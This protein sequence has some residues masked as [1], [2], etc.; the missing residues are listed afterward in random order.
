MGGRLNQMRA[1][2][3]AVEHGSF[4]AAAD[5]LGL[6]P[7]MAGRHI[8]DLERELRVRLFDRTTRQTRLTEAGAAYYERAKDALRAVAMADESVQAFCGDPT[9]TL[10][11]AAPV[12]FGSVCLVP[13]ISQFSKKY[14]AVRVELEL[15]ERVVDLIAEGFDLA[16][17]IGSLIDSSL[18][19][20]PLVPYEY[21][22][23]AAP[24]Y[25]EA[26]GA[27]ATP[28]DL[29]DHRCL[30]FSPATRPPDVWTLESGSVSRS[31]SV[32]VAL[33]INDMRTLRDTAI[34][35][36]GIALMPRPLIESEL[37]NGALTTVLRD[38]KVPSKDINVVYA[39]RQKLPKVTSF[40]EEAVRYF[41]ENRG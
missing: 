21:V 4:A 33:R 14:S 38:Y 25:I 18:I 2:V 32:P 22:V 39:S 23:C 9:G 17:R 1:M 26:Y 35:G 31:I 3:A 7:Q 13:L 19:A 5:I 40:V 11:I 29:A 30:V 15:S 27:P 24:A 8:R 12:G 41:A 28:D 10:R 34:S 20:R 36:S 16:V 37:L 6:S